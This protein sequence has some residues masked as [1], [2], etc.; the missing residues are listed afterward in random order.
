MKAAAAESAAAEGATAAAAAAAGAG[1]Q[2]HS[3]KHVVL[4]VLLCQTH[5]QSDKTPGPV[6]HPSTLESFYLQIW[7]ALWVLDALLATFQATSQPSKQLFNSL[8][9][10]GDTHILSRHKCMHADRAA[11]KRCNSQFANHQLDLQHLVL[12]SAKRLAPRASSPS[13][14]ASA[15]QPNARTSLSLGKRLSLCVPFYFARGLGCS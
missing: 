15:V 6:A 12:L 13:S 11:I 7:D 3:Q 10:R 5:H 9:L 1:G 2:Q 4:S 8:T 14:P